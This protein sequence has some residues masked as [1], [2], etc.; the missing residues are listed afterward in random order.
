MTDRP[1][2]PLGFTYDVHGNVL[3]HKDSN[4]FWEVYTRDENGNVLTYKNSNG[5]KRP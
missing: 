1:D 2:I 4:G 3:T 5:E